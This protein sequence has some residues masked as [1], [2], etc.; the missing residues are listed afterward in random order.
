MRGVSEALAV[1][2]ARMSST[3]LPG[4]TLADVA[5]EPM[6]ALLLRRLRRARRL[7]TIVLAT[8]DD[9]SD[10]ALAETAGRL[11]AQVCRGAREDVLGRFLGVIGEREGPIVRITADCP[12]IDPAII[13]AT[14]ELYLATSKC[15]Y[16][17]N[18]LPRCFPDG[19]D[20]EVIDAD[21]L[22]TIAH[23][24]LTASEREHVT[25]AV[26]A[27]PDR[28]VRASL[29]RSPSLGRL[30]WTVDERED[31]EFVRAVVERLG[32]R[33]YDAGLREILGAVR[34]GPSLAR[35]H[36]RRG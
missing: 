17:S 25:S 29:R 12:L 19:L 4:K 36:G 23:Q 5:G 20:V 28:F 21:A 15:A 27:Q 22:R 18:I 3:R 24:S 1:V 14:V 13:D 10:D 32:A 31:L 34:A 16:A 30:R 6:L 33:R 9:A 2:Q 26:R 11:G 35:Y 7:H 8:T